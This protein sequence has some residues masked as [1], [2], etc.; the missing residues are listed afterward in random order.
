MLNDFILLC[1]YVCVRLGLV[2]WNREG[3]QHELREEKKSKNPSK[4]CTAVEREP[5]PFDFIL[6]SL[7]FFYCFLYFAN[8]EKFETI[9]NE[10]RKHKIK[11]KMKHNS[12]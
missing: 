3:E 8:D 11:I 5:H 12:T 9:R 10:R 7:V 4:L 2:T 1:V 6:Y